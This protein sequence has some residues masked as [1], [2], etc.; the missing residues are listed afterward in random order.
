[1]ILEKQGCISDPLL[2]SEWD[3][4]KNNEFGLSPYELTPGSTKYAFW[5]CSKCGHKWKA[6]IARRSNGAGCRKCADRAIPDLKRKTLIKQG[7]GLSDKLLFKEWD[8]EKNPKK[9]TEYSYGSKEKVYWVCSVCGYKWSAAINS[10]HKGAGC[11]ACAGN[12]AVPGRN[13]L[14]TKKPELAKEWDYD[15]NIGITPD[16]VTYSSGKKYWWICPK[17]HESYYATPSHRVNGTG[18]PQCAK[19]I[20][21]KKSSK[22]IDQLSIDCEF[23]RTYNSAKEAAEELNLNQSA[24]CNAIRKQKTSGGYRWR[25]HEV[26]GQ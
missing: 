21:S 7:K 3:F 19:L 11:P 26:N 22:A 12:V 4:D 25:Y 23:I 1:M 14:A 15:K 5:I 17:G 2:L 16:Q 8:Y 20:L 9:P 10:R 6:P 24:I 13:D 18:C